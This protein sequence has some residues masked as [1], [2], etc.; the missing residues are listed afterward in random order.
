[1]AI[2]G[3]AYDKIIAADLSSG[4]LA[5]FQKLAGIP[6]Q[7]QCGFFGRARI[8]TRQIGNG[9]DFYA[10]QLLQDFMSGTVVPGL[11]LDKNSFWAI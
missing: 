8:A 9:L 1:V 7:D 3:I 6:H 4:T 11:L 2:P 5:F 10:G